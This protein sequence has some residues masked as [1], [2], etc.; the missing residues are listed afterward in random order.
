[1]PYDPEKRKLQEIIDALNDL[2][3]AEVGDEH[4]LRFAEGIA[5]RL[6]EDDEVMA[7]VCRHSK[8]EVMHG[9][10][11]QRLLEHVVDSMEDHEK[12]STEVL[13]NPITREQFSKLILQLLLDKAS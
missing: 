8:K 5:G 3:G 11:P 2:F 7:Q 1:K 6:R 9:L 12:L 13:E 10:L 4:K